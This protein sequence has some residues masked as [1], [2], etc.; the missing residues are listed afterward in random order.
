MPVVSLVEVWL[1]VPLLFQPTALP[2]ATRTASGENRYS[3]IVTDPAGGGPPPPAA[4]LVGLDPPHAAASTV[5]STTHR[6]RMASPWWSDVIGRR[7]GTAIRI[8]SGSCQRAGHSPRR[9]ALSRRSN[10]RDRRTASRKAVAVWNRARESLA[11]ARRNTSSSS[12]GTSRRAAARGGRS[13]VV[14]RAR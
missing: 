7:P 14:W 12:R 1:V 4:A 11:S 2:L 8:L 13:S 6:I 5:T 3:V 9:T 10:P